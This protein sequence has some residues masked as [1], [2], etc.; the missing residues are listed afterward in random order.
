MIKFHKKNFQTFEKRVSIDL[1][2]AAGHAESLQNHGK[3][4]GKFIIAA[5]IGPASTFNSQVYLNVNSR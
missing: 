4:P 2:H 3:I 5:R 1:P